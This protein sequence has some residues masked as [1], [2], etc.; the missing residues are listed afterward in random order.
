MAALSVNDVISFKPP[1]A[2]LTK[3]NLVIAAGALQKLWDE[4][5]KSMFIKPDGHRPSSSTFGALLAR[6]IFGGTLAGNSDHVFVLHGDII[7]DLNAGQ[8]DVQALEALA[9]I[10]IP[11]VLSQDAYREKLGN[12]L[13]KAE[14]W[15]Q[16]ALSEIK[17]PELRKHRPRDDSPSMSI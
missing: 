2:E 13:P 15:A 5:Q 16:V 4:H 6:E 7:V 9:H 12:H 17:G 11:G 14:S 1:K 10:N 3:E 8:P